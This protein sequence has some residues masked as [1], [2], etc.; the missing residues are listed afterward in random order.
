MAKRVALILILL[1]A[2]GGVAYYL[3]RPRST[4]LVLTGIVTTDDVIVS[5]QISGRIEK[6]FVKEG[7]TVSR[8]Q[9]LAEIQPE[10]L[11]AERAYYARSA[12]GSAFQVR[13]SEAALRYEEQRTA[14]QV[15]E[16]EASLEA[17]I[18]QQGEARANL[19]NA[20]LHFER[21]TELSRQGIAPP[22]QLDEART[23][24]DA[25]KARVDT[26]DKQVQAQRAAV[27]LAKSSAE[28]V[29]VRRSQLLESQ[30]QQAAAQ[31]QQTKADV[32]L[33]Y[34]RIVSPLD[35]I[36]DVV[37]ARTG[38]VVN[39]GE[40]IL[41]LI[42]PDN[43]WVRADVEETYIDRVR[44]GDDLTLRLPSGEERQGTVFYRAVDAGF[45]TQRDVSRT[46]RDIKTFQIRLRADNADRRLAVGMTVYVLF[47][48]AP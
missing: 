8:Q 18:A 22:Q 45:A 14:H 10:E 23:A 11:Q 9:I 44:L 37:A 19:E 21:Q 32:R 29:A 43:L 3:T 35:G 15:Q 1:F 41:T 12:E 31:A 6:L 27:A 36:V 40:A 17:A 16:A 33:N 38:E 4:A 2:A 30:Q 46:K 48:A 28:Q 25:A 26:L 42:D 7:D 47:P 24:Y 34:A 13:E 20:R 39:P 5:P